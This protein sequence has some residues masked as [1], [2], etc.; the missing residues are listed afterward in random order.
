MNGADYWHRTGDLLITS[1]LVYKPDLRILLAH[2][3]VSLFIRN[4]LNY[5]F[6]T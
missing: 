1:Q 4:N 5:L 6:F 3:G 2:V